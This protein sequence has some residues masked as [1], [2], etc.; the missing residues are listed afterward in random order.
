MCQ[1]HDDIYN[2]VSWYMV[3]LPSDTVTVAQFYRVEGAPESV[4]SEPI[5]TP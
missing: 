1:R 4:P 3:V 5:Q 2:S